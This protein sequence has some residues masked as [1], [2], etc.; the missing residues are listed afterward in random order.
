MDEV[1]VQLRLED[2]WDRWQKTG[3]YAVSQTKPYFFKKFCV[4]V[5]CMWNLADAQARFLQQMLALNSRE[6]KSSLAMEGLHEIV[7]PTR[8]PDI[9]LYAAKFQQVVLD[10]LQENGIALHYTLAG[11]LYGEYCRILQEKAKPL[12]LTYLGIARRELPRPVVDLDTYEWRTE[13][14]EEEGV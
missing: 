12:P 4:Y 10:V 14:Y 13:G 2:A 5:V 6:V 7:H 3:E 9:E 1:E 8:N 11:F